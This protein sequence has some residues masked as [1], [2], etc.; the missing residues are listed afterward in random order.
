MLQIATVIGEVVMNETAISNESMT[1]TAVQATPV[2]P[3]HPN[4][5]E[6]VTLLED[7]GLQARERTALRQVLH[8]T[9]HLVKKRGGKLYILASDPA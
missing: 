8:D 3:D 7:P 1:M 6:I 5:V 2:I 9:V 4:I